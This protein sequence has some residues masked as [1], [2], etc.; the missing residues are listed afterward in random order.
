[1]MEN[2]Y[3][4]LF[5]S[6]EA[7]S[8]EGIPALIAA[9]ALLRDH[10]S[11]ATLVQVKYLSLSDVPIRALTLSI[12]CEDASGTS[13]EGVADFQYSNLDVRRNET[14]GAKIAVPVPDA[15]TRVVRLAIKKLELSDGTV[16]TASKA[17]SA[18]R[19]SPQRS[20]MDLLDGDE[21]LVRQ[22]H[23]ETGTSGGFAP[24]TAAD[25]WRC[26]CGAVNYASETVCSKC[27]AEMQAQFA[28]L[29][30][31]EWLADRKKFRLEQER[32]LR[33]REGRGN[34][35]RADD[36]KE[37]GRPRRR[38]RLIAIAAIAVITLALGGVLLSRLLSGRAS[39]PDAMPMVVAAANSAQPTEKPTAAPTPTVSPDPYGERI[40]V[41]SGGDFNLTFT[42]C[43]ERYEDVFNAAFGEEF[44]A[45]IIRS[46]YDADMAV[47]NISINGARAPFKLYF[48][49]DGE[50][51]PADGR[52]DNMFI[53]GISDEQSEIDLFN[54]LAAGV[55][56]IT[57]AELYT[58]QD[59]LDFAMDMA[60]QAA[61]SASESAEKTLDGKL[62]MLLMPTPGNSTPV[63][64][65]GCRV[66]E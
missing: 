22:Y 42:E 53:F 20:L 56:L 62:Y 51:P 31:L 66:E 55:L 36:R 26:A 21:E 41:I 54:L 6:R 15:N 13:L 57:N 33:E 63:M 24:D 43:A 1:M 48:L 14:F 27:R 39:L 59:A 28:A 8:F 34:P 38:T 2:R 30:D 25:Y 12:S 44:D 10:G 4:R 23:I 40:E 50:D 47:Y 9:F 17:V 65:M 29:R 61:G 18:R 5:E 11:G 45:E 60:E 46:D 58:A 52:F 3:E 35:A 32:M 64:S 7:S 37:R 49:R 19:I 16:L